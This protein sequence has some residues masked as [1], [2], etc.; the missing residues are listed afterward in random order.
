MDEVITDV[1]EID[2][3]EFFLVNT[4]DKYSFFAEVGNT[5]NVY[6]LKEVIEDGEKYLVNLDNTHELEQAFLLY[7]EKY[8][9][10]S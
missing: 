9:D 5:S 2:G 1:V 10:A 6:V 7:N 3:V 4:V 8:G